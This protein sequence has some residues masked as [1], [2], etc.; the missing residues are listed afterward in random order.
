MV[1][2]GYV[3][4]QISMNRI[5]SCQ[6]YNGILWEEVNCSVWT[7]SRWIPASYYDV[8]TLT[9][10]YDIADGF[11]S[12]IITTDDGFYSWFSKDFVEYKEKAL[13]FFEIST[14]WLDTNKEIGGGGGTKIVINDIDINGNIHVDNDTTIDVGINLKDFVKDGY[15]TVSST[16]RGF[17]VLF[18]G[19]VSSIASDVAVFFDFYSPEGEYFDSVNSSG[20]GGSLWDY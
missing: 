17:Y 18:A 12:P 3:W 6:V 10:Y 5:I 13:E 19:F 4:F 15:T 20:G 9:D 2:R 7:G 11:S 16:F 14:T 1:E 8:L